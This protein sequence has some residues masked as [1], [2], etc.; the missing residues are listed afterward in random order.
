MNDTNHR[1]ARSSVTRA[2]VADSLSTHGRLI[3]NLTHP[4]FGMNTC[5][6]LLLMRLTE[7]SVDGK[8]LVGTGL[9][10]S[11]SAKVVWSLPPVLK[12][13]I[14]ISQGLLLDRR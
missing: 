9:T 8:A 7:R 1:L 13:S 11:W 4:H 2:E 6:H 12:S 10:P 5:P 3:R 14:Q